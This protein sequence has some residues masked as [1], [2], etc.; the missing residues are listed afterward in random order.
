MVGGDDPDAIPADQD[1]L[2]GPAGGDSIHDTDGPEA[3]AMR[4]VEEDDELET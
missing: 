4:V 2:G 1:V 3:S